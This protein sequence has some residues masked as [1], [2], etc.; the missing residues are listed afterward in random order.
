MEEHPIC[1]QTIK[2]LTVKYYDDHSTRPMTSAEKSS[3]LLSCT[4]TMDDKTMAR[5]SRISTLINNLI[6]DAALKALKCEDFQ[7]ERGI[8]KASLKKI[9]TIIGAK[10]D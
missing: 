7:T 10:E 2:D 5:T 9:E 3:L 1:Y 6:Q 4:L 8:S